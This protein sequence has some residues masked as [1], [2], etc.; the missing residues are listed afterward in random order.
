MCND[1]GAFGAQHSAETLENVVDD[2][3]L[4]RHNSAMLSS[5]SNPSNIMLNFSSVEYYLRV[6]RRMSLITLA[7]PVC[8]V[9]DFCLIF[10]PLRVITMNQKL[11]L[12]QYR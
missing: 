10:I 12:M 7:A 6:A 4:R 1:N 11:S 2:H 8:R 9:C 5:P 3:C